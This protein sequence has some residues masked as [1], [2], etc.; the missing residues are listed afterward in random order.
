[1]LMVTVFEGP[2]RAFDPG[3]AWK[4]CCWY[5]AKG[6][7]TSVVRA[8]ANEDGPKTVRSERRHRRRETPKFATARGY[9][10]EIYFL[11][12]LVHNIG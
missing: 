4:F 8:A 12:E 10:A 1:M 7:A 9:L 11:I 5:D 6:D 2:V 3:K